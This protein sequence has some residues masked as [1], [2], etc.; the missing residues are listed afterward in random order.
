MD[1]PITGEQ[2]RISAG[3][4]AAV[5]TELGGSLRELT[6][7]GVPLI[8]GYDADEL[9]PAAAGQLLVPW[10]N[11]IDHGRYDF[12]GAAH[13][14]PIDE[15]DRHN[16]IHGLA[17]WESWALAEHEPYRVRLT[18]RLLG[19]PGYPFCV[20]LAVEYVLDSVDGLSVRLSAHNTGRRPAPYGHGAHPYLTLGRPID[21]CSLLVPA[22]AYL[23][24][25]E[26]AIPAA[27]PTGVRGTAYDFR[28]EH[29]LGTAVL[30]NAFTALDRD[31]DGLAW[32]RL[33]DGSRS[34]ALWID[35]A[36]PWL[37]LFTL[38]SAPDDLRR[39][40]LGT[41]PMTCPP[42]AF[43]TGTD[44]ISLKPGARFTGSWGITG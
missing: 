37:E 5:V 18:H 16:A 2:F 40:G 3:G 41:E 19:R 44:L 23:Q 1:R 26:R 14:L 29:P 12:D 7:D 32:V 6:H 35:D 17:R 20:D 31:P 15:P 34:V 21:E 22:D 38:D 36:H 33:S 30:D 13:E 39:S 27:A 43:V 28:V 42:N 25:D 4:Y 11:R 8:L 24:V 10:P 9:P